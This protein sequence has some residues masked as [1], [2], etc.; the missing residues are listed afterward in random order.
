MLIAGCGS[1]GTIEPIH[2][3]AEFGFN[4]D[5]SPGT[6][7][8]QAKLDMPVRRLVVP[9]NAVEPS[10]GRWDWS[11]YDAYYEDVL[12]H[13]LKP[14][15]VAIGGPCWAAASCVNGVGVPDPSSDPDWSGY[16]TR[17]AERYPDAI[18]I[19]IWNEPNSVRQ[20]P[21]HPDAVRY[22][23]L[24]AAAYRAVKQVDPRMPVV[25]GG[26]LPAT[27]TGFSGTADSSF[28]AAIY[29]AG[30]GKYMDAIGAH[31]YPTSI[32]PGG[33][34]GTY[35]PGATE[36]DLER[37]RAVRDAAGHPDT[38]IWVTEIG[39]STGDGLSFTAGTD[40]SEQADDLVALLRTLG[41]E[42]DVH[43]VLVHR[44]V[45]PPIAASAGPAA[46]LQSGFGVFHADHSP[47]RAAC[48]LSQAFGG[49]LR[50]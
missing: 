27:T 25:S 50:C 16:V 31:P 39:V 45:D 37:V 19:E 48:A 21:P 11:R 9:W 34:S 43:V 23:S 38:P 13:G 2:S 30:A 12:R 17:L 5:P 3:K 4:D 10:R 32:L 14:L 35:D 20:F 22:T 7:A 15:I 47:K 41:G 28:L 44:L 36:S 33:T 8:L 49:R 46:Q 26:L 1:S 29:R 40:E 42:P 18:G 6:F 24:L